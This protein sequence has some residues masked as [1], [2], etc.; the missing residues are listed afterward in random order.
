MSGPSIVSSPAAAPPGPGRPAWHAHMAFGE[1][2]RV[3]HQ[4]L[5]TNKLR[6]TL[7]MLGIVISVGAV[8]TMLALGRGA[9]EAVQARIASLG[10]TMLTVVP[11]QVFIGG[12]A[13]ASDRAR[14]TVDDA[15]MLA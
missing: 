5:R 1:T 15:T 14:L 4:A 11:G 6:S 7:T 13:S 10:T 2:T 12:V 3:A 9:Q 8:I